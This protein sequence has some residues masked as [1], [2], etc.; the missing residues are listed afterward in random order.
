MAFIL[1]IVA[2]MNSKKI[3]KVCQVLIIWIKSNIFSQEGYLV[4]HQGNVPG[5]MII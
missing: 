4:K 5:N 1:Q 2:I 3:K